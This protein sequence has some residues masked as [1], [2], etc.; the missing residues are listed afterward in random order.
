MHTV[1]LC[2]YIYVQSRFLVDDSFGFVCCLS[3]EWCIELEPSSMVYKNNKHH[4]LCCSAL[5]AI[6][7]SWLNKHVHLNTF[8]FLNT[9]RWTGSKEELLRTPSSK[10]FFPL[11]VIIT[12]NAHVDHRS[13][14]AYYWQDETINPLWL[15]KHVC[16]GASKNLIFLV[17]ARMTGINM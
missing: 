6:F 13:P 14:L 7:F 11:D 5:R 17:F 16:F 9:K 15:C 10:F 4:S 8:F 3:E 2:I 1:W 12:P